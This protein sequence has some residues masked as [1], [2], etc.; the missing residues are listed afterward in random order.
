M[1]KRL[2]SRW[3]T[4]F[5][6]RLLNIMKS[7]TTSTKN[8]LHTFHKSIEARTIKSGVRLAGLAMLGEQLRSYE[9]IF[10]DLG[11]Q[12]L[13]IINECQRDANREFVA[14]VTHNLLSAYTYCR[15]E[16]GNDI[17]RLTL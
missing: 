3:E 12:M 7:F 9:V 8:P 11:I 1:I 17:W 14:V 2:G 4:A 6:R 16:R 10:E 15:N 13:V 5:I